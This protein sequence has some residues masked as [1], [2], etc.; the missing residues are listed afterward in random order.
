MGKIPPEYK[1]EKKIQT[2]F[3]FLF[4]FQTLMNVYRM[5]VSV[6]MDDA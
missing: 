6:I 1:K 5:A 3:F 2:L 4:G